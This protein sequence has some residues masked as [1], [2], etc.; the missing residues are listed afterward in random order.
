M[1]GLDII[2][3][4]LFLFITGLALFIWGFLCFRWKR[5]IENIP[6]SK[7]RSIAM[8]LVEIFGEVTPS[9]HGILKSPFSQSDCVY[10]KYQ[11]DE[12]RSTGKHSQ[13]IT[14]SKGHDYRRFHLKDETGKVLVNPHMAKIDI[15]MDNQFKSAPGR[16][17]PE[18]A[19][20]FLAAN[21]ISYEGFLLGINRTMR[22]L[23]W[24]IAPGDKL[25]ILGTAADNPYVEEGTVEKGVDDVM[26]KKGEYDKFYYISDRGERSVLFKFKAKSYAG[27]I[28]GIVLTTI[29]IYLIIS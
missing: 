19:K 10:Y 17:P 2:I 13:W 6:T 26:I 20:P 1:F 12:L 22:Y 24:F 29:G 3:F 8:G 27:I 23:E 4:F 28:F 5:L 18:T 14:V 11:V 15:P 21:K 25:Y 7:I 16:D 9:R